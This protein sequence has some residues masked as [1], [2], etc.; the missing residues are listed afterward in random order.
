MEGEDTKAILT[1][2]RQALS[3]TVPAT[4]TLRF[5]SAKQAWEELQKWMGPE[6]IYI[7]LRDLTT[8]ETFSWMGGKRR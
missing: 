1:V 3:G 2:R 5:S 8:G 7:E 6:T 4:Y